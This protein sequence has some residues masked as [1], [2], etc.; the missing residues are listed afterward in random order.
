[1]GGIYSADATLIGGGYF[2]VECIVLIYAFNEWNI[3]FWKALV[4]DKETLSSGASQPMD[5]EISCIV[6]EGN[7]KFPGIG[8]C[9][10]LHLLKTI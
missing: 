4:V 2:Q 5:W 8:T 7:G 1:M 6:A 10:Q 3:V 9:S